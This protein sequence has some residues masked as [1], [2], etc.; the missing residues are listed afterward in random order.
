MLDPGRRVRATVWTFLGATL[1]VAAAGWCDDVHLRNGNVMQGTATT[2]ENGD[3]AIT[4]SM[5]TWVVPGEQVD[6]VVRAATF[7]ADVERRLAARS[8]WSAEELYGLAVE[9][10]DNGATT[11]ARRLLWRVLDLDPDHQGAR[12]RL[13]FRWQD[14]RWVGVQE[15]ADLDRRQ[16]AQEAAELRRGMLEERTLLAERR[17]VAAEERAAAAERNRAPSRAPYDPFGLPVDLIWSSSV[18]GSVV[19]VP[20]VFPGMQAAPPHGSNPPRSPPRARPKRPVAPASPPPASSHS[21]FK[22]ASGSPR[23]R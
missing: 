18:G 21:S 22:P 8:N 11:L 10:A 5:G 13:G 4:S 19:V 14:G 2:L 12:R 17:A 15:Q 3:V 1:L 7:E 20:P 16:R 9:C 6:H 23:G